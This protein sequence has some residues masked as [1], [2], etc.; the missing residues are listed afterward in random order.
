MRQECAEASHSVCDAR[1]LASQRFIT[2]RATNSVAA[3]IFQD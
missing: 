2:A 1:F 3:S